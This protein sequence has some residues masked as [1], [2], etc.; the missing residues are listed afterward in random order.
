MK[1]VEKNYV[2][3][4]VT[5]KDYS[6]IMSNHMISSNAEIL[7]KEELLMPNV[8]IGEDNRQ[9]VETTTNFPY[10]AVLYLEVTFPSGQTGSGT[11]WMI[12]DNAAATAAHCLYD[13]NYGGWATTVK[14]WPGRNGYWSTPYGSATQT[15][16]ITSEAYVNADN[17]IQV[18]GT[19]KNTL[20]GIDWGLIEL[21]KDLGTDTG[22]ISFA[23]FS[24]TTV[25][26]RAIRITGYP[27]QYQ[28]YQYEMLSSITDYTASTLYFNNIDVTSGQSG[29]PVMGLGNVAFGIFTDEYVDEV[30]PKNYGVRITQGIYNVFNIFI[31]ECT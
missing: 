6:E 18:G 1:V 29:S 15:R 13:P 30:D 20:H 3:G 26:N 22:V 5:Y 2:S 19:L 8:I 31:S 14:V 4:E 11:A 10:S 24:D 7:E 27:L 16:I 25:A 12:S 21:N 9:I 17:W 23:Y 28:Y